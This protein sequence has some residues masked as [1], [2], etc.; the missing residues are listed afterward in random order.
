[1]GL[2]K[3]ILTILVIVVVLYLIYSYLY[4]DNNISTLK[5]GQKPETISASSLPS[6]NNANN[7]TYSCWIYI[8]NWNFRLGENKVILQ[9]GGNAQGGGNPAITLGKYEND[10]NIELNTYGPKGHDKKSFS[11]GVQNIPLQRWVNIII[12]LNGRSLDV[13]ID[14]KLVRTCVLPGVAR[15]D[16][17]DNIFITP[18]GGFDGWTGRMQFWPHPVNPQEAFNI[19]RNGPGTSGTNF[20]N[21]YRIKFSYL[22]DNVEKGSFEI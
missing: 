3:N 17:T 1:M 11:C 19:Y 16:N 5:S 2:I 13:Y 20:F 8:K 7:Y 21:K 22:V 12:S 10:V 14:G 15:A 18:S 4:P 9:R 6:G